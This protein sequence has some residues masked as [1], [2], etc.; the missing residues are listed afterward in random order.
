MSRPP[1]IVYLVLAHK[2]EPLKLLMRLFGE[3]FDCFVHVDSRVP[4]G[5]FNPVRSEKVRLIEKRTPIFWCGANMMVATLDLI[6]TAMAA[7]PDF[8]RIALISGDSLPAT[9]PETLE[10]ALG[11][12]DV[13]FIE[14]AEVQ[15]DPTLRNLDPAVAVERYG[16]RQPARFQTFV[17]WDH[18]LLNPRDRREA[19]ARYTGE[20]EALRNR[21]RNEVETI[22]STI[23]AD[24][25]PRPNLFDTFYYGSQWWAVSRDAML[26]M[27]D[28]LFSD[29]VRNY[30]RYF[31]CPDEHFIHCV[32]GNNPVLK[33]RPRRPFMFS[34][35]M[36]GGGAQELH[37]EQARL[38]SVYPQTKRLFARKFDPSASQDIVESIKKGR[39]FLD[40]YLGGVKPP[41][42][43]AQPL[44]QTVKAR[45]PHWTAQLRLYDA[46]KSIV[47]LAHGSRGTYQLED[48]VLTVT[49]EKFPPDV[50]LQRAGEYVHKDIAASDPE[51]R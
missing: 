5:P 42:A 14:T 27:R 48:G 6:E 45:H 38:R 12:L 44:L 16:W 50:F 26:A 17:Y 15:N 21:L 3:R 49:W 33:A 10:I 1:K 22:A 40:L 51:N 37:L 34:A 13:E 24:L 18:E 11:A 31:R 7:V 30:F 8:D 36:Q 46:D 35:H 20:S 39:Y 43:A 29:E 2:P 9:T 41:A 47:H 25:P 19:A 32:F 4:I 23:L 28:Q